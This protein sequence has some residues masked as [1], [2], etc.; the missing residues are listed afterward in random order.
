MIQRRS[1]MGG[2]AGLGA[3]A[4]MPDRVVAQGNTVKFGF[5]GP[6]TGN[7][8][9][10]GQRFRE[11]GELFL[12]QTNAAGGLAGRR[13]VVDFQDDRGDPLQSTNIAQRFVADAE[14]VAAIGSFTSTS[15]MA[16]GQIFAQARMPQVSPTSSHPDY[17]KISPY[18]F[19]MPNTQDIVAELNAELMVNRL[20]TKRIALPYFQDD[21][22][23]FV[24]QATKAEIEK[25]GGEVIL[26]EAMTQQA[27]D[28]RAMI[29]KIR[30]ARAD[31]IFI[32]SH[33]APSA[34]FMQQLRQAGITVPVGGADPLYNPEFL[35]LA[36]AAAEGVICTTYFF[37]S[38][39]SKAAF[40]EGYKAKYGREPDQWAAFA[41]DAIAIAAEGAKALITAG[42]PVTREALR[43][44]IDALPPYDGASGVTEFVNGSPRKP[45][46]LL[47][48]R[49]GRYELYS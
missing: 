5:F 43:D 25:R 18:Q 28:F 23:I 44:A 45:M 41:Y 22:G 17:T 2:L 24:A 19:R 36:G 35:R 47:V 40:T 10:N 48:I 4:L 15:S 14:V 38:D 13:L 42:R 29:T 6:F 30:A 11:A 20:G 1:L 32:A 46:T 3:V 33:Y 8:A 12:E 49:N 31:G 26:S 37:P 21:W 27:R 34:I 9:A 7:F 39:P 16:A